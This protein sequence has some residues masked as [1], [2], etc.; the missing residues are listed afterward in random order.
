MLVDCQHFEDLAEDIDE[1]GIDYVE[2]RTDFDQTGLVGMVLDWIHK[3]LVV[4]REHF[5]R[6]WLQE[7]NYL[8]AEEKRPAVDWMDF[9]SSEG[10]TV[11]N[12]RR[13]LTRL[14]TDVSERA[15]KHSTQHTETHIETHTHTHRETRRQHFTCT[16]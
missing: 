14:R 8:M 9:A 3:N 2:G 15:H 11:L 6:N 5:A 1:F 7:T 10:S 13:G 12:R 4:E 16:C